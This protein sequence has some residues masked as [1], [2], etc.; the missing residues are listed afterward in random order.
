[1]LA[2]PSMFHTMTA[3][4]IARM[5]ADNDDFLV[6]APT[7]QDLCNLAKPLEQAWQITKQTLTP[8]E[9]IEK[10]ATNETGPPNSFQ[11]VGLKITRLSSGGINQ[12]PDNNTK[13]LK[14]KEMDG[15][16]SVSIPYVINADLSKR[17]EG[18]STVDN[19]AYM[20]DV[21][22]LR[23]IAG[24]THPGIAY[25]VGVLGRHLHDPCQRHVDALKPI[26]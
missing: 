20:K 17:K 25:I 18:E 6:I 2:E 19:K 14:E 12:Q 23:F 1:M 16:N 4:G 9:F 22:T 3:N 26:F 24:T 10:N 8:E 21:G 13:L 5:E 11:H 7:I 15:S